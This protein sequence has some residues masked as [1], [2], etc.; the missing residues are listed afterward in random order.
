VV[1]VSAEGAR[2]GRV[3]PDFTL[4]QKALDAGA[5]ILTDDA[6]N[7]Q[8]SYNEG[9]RQVAAYLQAHGYEESAPGRWT[10]AKPAG[11]GNARGHAQPLTAQVLTPSGFR[12]MG[13]I[14]P[15]DEVIAANGEV[16]TVEAVFPQGQRPVWKVTLS[17]GS[18][19]RCTADHLWRARS[20]TEDAPGFG[21]AVEFEV[22]P[23]SKIMMEMACGWRFVLPPL[24]DF[25]GFRF[26][27]DDAA[28]ANALEEAALARGMRGVI[29]PEGRIIAPTPGLFRPRTPEDQRRFEEAMRGLRRDLKALKAAGLAEDHDRPVR[30]PY[31]TLPELASE[32]WHEP[33]KIRHADDARERV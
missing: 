24:G 9:E 3:E 11:S 14:A 32:P 28:L 6:D 18:T 27:T 26:A 23:L 31:S 5:T 22:L 25:G 8:R 4:L 7:R 21:E 2:R 16:T 10:P 19:T 13:D 30:A 12:L 15:G 20:E 1:F 17:D 33:G 29:L